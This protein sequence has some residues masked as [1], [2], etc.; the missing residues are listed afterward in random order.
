MVT[1]LTNIKKKNHFWGAY[2]LVILVEEQ[3]E[4]KTSSLKISNKSL[5]FKTDPNRRIFT[6]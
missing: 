1:S 5:Y 2:S 3:N 4:D 6:N